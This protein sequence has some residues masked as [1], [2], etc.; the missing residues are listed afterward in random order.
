M[1]EAKTIGEQAYRLFMEEGDEKASSEEKQA[2]AF[3]I[4]EFIMTEQL[5]DGCIGV[6]WEDDGKQVER[7][8]LE[9]AYLIAPLAIRYMKAQEHVYQVAAVRGF[10]YY[11]REFRQLMNK[12][13]KDSAEEL[14]M[15]REALV[16]AA[17]LM[18]QAAGFEKYLMFADEWEVC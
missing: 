12:A 1:I 2:K 18:Y 9:G 8:G 7:Q 17:R 13:E 6:K 16:R 3:Q 5:I 14:R 4:C 11:E 10:A 15:G